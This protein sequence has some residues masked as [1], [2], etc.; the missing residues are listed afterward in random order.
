M[1]KKS[2]EDVSVEVAG[3][4]CVPWSG[5]DDV[6]DIRAFVRADGKRL[7]VEATEHQWKFLEDMHI[8]F[9]K[10]I[11]DIGCEGFACAAVDTAK[12]MARH[13]HNEELFEFLHGAICFELEKLPEADTR[14]LCISLK[15]QRDEV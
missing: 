4:T 12:A 1:E 10:F 15:N 2:C 7:S 8:W 14:E 3:M 11:C 13:V 6:I 9:T 5:F